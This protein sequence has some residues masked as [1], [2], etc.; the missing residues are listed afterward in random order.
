MSLRGGRNLNRPSPVGW[1]RTFLVWFNIYVHSSRVKMKKKE[2]DFT[3]TKVGVLPDGA[4]TKIRTAYLHR[5]AV[6][7]LKI[8]K[9]MKIV[10]ACRG[11]APHRV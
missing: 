7:T 6:L 3:G 2:S 8:F 1:W 9:V 4:R 11:V 10:V 5:P